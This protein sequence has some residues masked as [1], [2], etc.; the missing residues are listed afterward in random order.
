MSKLDISKVIYH[1]KNYFCASAFPQKVHYTAF[2]LFMSGECMQLV[3]VWTEIVP[4]DVIKK[5]IFYIIKINDIIDRLRKGY[6]I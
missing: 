4:F 6:T 3:C 5:V 1:G 2:E